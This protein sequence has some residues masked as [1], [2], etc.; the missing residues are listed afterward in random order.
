VSHAQIN[1]ALA[2]VVEV[3]LELEDPFDNKGLCGIFLPEHFF[4]VEQV[5]GFTRIPLPKTD[6]QCFTSRSG[7]ICVAS[8]HCHSCADGH[9]L[10][11]R[12]WL[13]RGEKPCVDAI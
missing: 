1:L 13:T 9:E 11:G 4:E 7:P 10:D 6:R 8:Q 5:D 2:G 3:S 12:F